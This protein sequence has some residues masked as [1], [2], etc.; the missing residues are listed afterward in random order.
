MQ[1]CGEL[2]VVL[3]IERNFD[4]LHIGT[5][6]GLVDGLLLDIGHGSVS[7][8]LG[9]L[10]DN[11]VVNMSLISKLLELG[12]DLDVVLSGDYDIL[13]LNLDLWAVA[14]VSRAENGWGDVERSDWE[15]S[16]GDGD[17]VGGE[18]GGARDE[19]GGARG[20]AS[21]SAQRGGASSA[22][23]EHRAGGQ[24]SRLMCVKC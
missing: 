18:D 17:G 24:Y 3:S 13:L 14:E 8:T 6:Q 16:L 9:D 2:V 12:D 4:Y 21:D 5:L 22:G 23:V 7:H 19:G 20:N 10:G 15:C 1:Y 11:M